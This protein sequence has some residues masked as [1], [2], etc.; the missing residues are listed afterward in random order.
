MRKLITTSA[1]AAV[2]LTASLV[3]WPTRQSSAAR[4][5][6][7]LRQLGAKLAAELALACPHTP[8]RDV[9][10]FQ[11]CATTLTQSTDIPFARTVLWG[12]EQANLRIKNRKLTR[13]SADVF[14]NNYLP[15]MTFTGRYTIDRDAQDNIDIIRVEAYFR[16]ALPAG[17]YP[18]PF[19]HSA[20]KWD[21]Y[22]TMNLVNFYLDDK[23]HIVLA[24]RG[25]N[26]S[27]A[28]KGQYARVTPPA[29]VKDQWTW[30]D[31]AGQQQPRVMLFASRYQAA[32][33]QL[34]R[35]DDA[36]RT[37]ATTI[38]ESSCLSCHTPNN[39]ATATRLILLQT[40]LHAAGEIDAVIKAVQGEAM[41]LDEIGLPA[42]IDPKQRAAIL[43]TAMAFRAE[44]TAADKW[45][46]SQRQAMS[47]SDL[48]PASEAQPGR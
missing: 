46:A 37:F 16:N 7:E 8:N 33:P 36:Y 4:S 21:A 13:F 6:D 28:N 15:L 30:T 27:D 47:S 35:L 18:Y 12:G 5:Q 24:T 44:L 14:R 11:T 48:I 41:P 1:L 40:P 20:D 39:A 19:W 3:A 2:A 10:A 43:R 26:G 22:E 32:N 34:Q 31:G 17:D 25:S 38:R 29:F 45:E 42:D 23:G 9:A